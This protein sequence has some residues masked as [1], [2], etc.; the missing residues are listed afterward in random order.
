MHGIRLVTFAMSIRLFR[1]MHCRKRKIVPLAILLTIALTVSSATFA[2]QGMVWIGAGIMLDAPAHGLRIVSLP[3]GSPAEKA[4]VLI[5][6]II[7]GLDGHDFAS[8]PAA[9]DG[10]FRTAIM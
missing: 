10:Q 6:D 3:Y 8:E 4:G 2:L 1:A 5:D 9:L 7:V